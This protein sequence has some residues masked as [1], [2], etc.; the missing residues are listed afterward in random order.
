MTPGT[1]GSIRCSR[2]RE[3]SHGAPP[4]CLTP[5]R[6]SVPEA[7]AYTILSEVVYNLGRAER[8]LTII[9]QAAHDDERADHL[10]AIQAA[11]EQLETFL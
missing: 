6:Q 10:V 11:R 4:A 1:P 7:G 3:R 2:R 9:Q 8:A 5:Q